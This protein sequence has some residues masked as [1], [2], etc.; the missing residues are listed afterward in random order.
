MKTN[1]PILLAFEE[2]AVRIIIDASQPLFVAKDVCEVL[3][4]S[5]YRDVVAKLEDD[6]RVSTIVDT[7]G[8]KQEMTAITESGLYALIF[9]SDKPEA[10]RFRK[11]VTAEVLPAIRRSGGYGVL[12]P[13]DEIR[14]MNQRLA[15]LKELMRVRN[16]RY[17]EDIYNQYKVVSE[18]LGFAIPALAEYHPPHPHDFLDD[19]TRAVLDNFWHAY[20]TLTDTVGIA[21]NH[22]RDSDVIAINLKEILACAAANG[23]PVP[24]RAELL[25]A[26]PQCREPV[27]IGASVTVASR[28]RFTRKGMADSVRCYLFRPSLQEKP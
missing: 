16:P 25:R 28:I 7:L 3:G 12:S 26:L 5:K 22:H 17:R 10:K 1:S 27:F 15:L 20:H 9:K 13:A 24:S 18:R 2:K 4:I 8:G 19:A 6:E 23:I 11:W 21:L 14:Y